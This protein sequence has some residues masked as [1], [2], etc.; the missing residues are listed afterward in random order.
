M[1][2]CRYSAADPRRRKFRL[3]ERGR[4]AMERERVPHG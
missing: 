1:K 4:V 2:S 3:G